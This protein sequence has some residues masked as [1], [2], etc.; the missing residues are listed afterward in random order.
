MARR[1]AKSS[2]PEARPLLL[3]AIER[4]RTEARVLPPVWAE[5]ESELRRFSRDKELYAYQRDAVNN[6][7]WA[8]WM[9]YEKCGDYRPDE[10]AEDAETRKRRFAMETLQGGGSRINYALETW[11]IHA[12]KEEDKDRGAEVF[13]ALSERIRPAGTEIPFDALCNRMGFWMATGSGKTLVMVKLIENLRRL[14]DAGEIPERKVLIL[15]PGSLLLEQIR[16]TVA[17]YNRASRRPMDLVSLREWNTLRGRGR[18]AIFYYDAANISDERKQ[19]RVDWRDFENNGEWYVLLDEAHRGTKGD[20]KRQ[21]YYSLL[22]REG[23]LFNFSATFADFLDVCTTGARFNL[24]DFIQEGYGKH[25]CLCGSDFREFAARDDSR[26]LNAFAKGEY[27]DEEK[28][29]VVLKSALALALVKGEIKRLREAAKTQ[30]FSPPPYHDPLMVTMTHSV[31]TPRSDLAA[32]FNILAG[33]AAPEGIDAEEFALARREFA[34]DLREGSFLFEDLGQRALRDL[35]KRAEKLTEADAR[36]A[37]FLTESPGSL[38]IVKGESGKEIAIQLQTAAEP[39]GLIRIGDTGK[40]IKSAEEAGI[41]TGETVRKESFF[42]GL[43]TSRI[44]ALMGSRAFVESW[45]S[46]RP[47]VLNFVNI[48]TVKE[49]MKF[50]VQSIG[51]GVRVRPLPDQRRRTSAIRSEMSGAKRRVF[52]DTTATAAA[53]SLFVFAARRKAV[54]GALQGLAKEAASDDWVRLE[55]VFKLNPRPKLPDGR[56]M[57]LLVPKY[58]ETK[59]PRKQWREFLITEDSER[60]ILDFVTPMPACVLA[61]AHEKS[62]AEIADFRTMTAEG[63]F[64]R[65]TESGRKFHSPVSAI[66][67]V[68]D[69][70]RIRAEGKKAESVRPLLA[71][72]IVH[73]DRVEIRGGKE[74]KK[75]LDEKLSGVSDDM[76]RRRTEAEDDFLAKRIS[77]EEFRRIQRECSSDPGTRFSEL[78]VRDLAKHYYTPLVAATDKDKANYIRRIV[79]EESEVR[80]LNDLAE[81][82]DSI[83]DG[84]EGWMFSKLDENT[85]KVFI[86]YIDK[87][88]LREFHPDFVFWM[89]RG[90]E[91]RIVFV[92]PKGMAHT[93]YQHKLDGYARL[94]KEKGKLRKF[95]C[96]EWRKVTVALLCYNPDANEA[97]EQYGEYWTDDPSNIFAD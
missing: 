46:A 25:I 80:F 56:E 40:W 3:A 73:F 36:R 94:F 71:S 96:E 2:G 75:L 60:R 22:A 34:E 44:S 6:A 41:V 76:E 74:E 89:C 37:V 38:E 59:L 45:D 85:D 81:K 31:N 13:A 23:F 84:W 77:R 54:A 12:H 30:G 50:I 92:D 67:G 72:D 27:G 32:Y 9:Y 82:A 18:D 91:Y 10:T 86:P 5:S 4:A 47:N 68:F 42:K 21:A 33:L 19:V 95:E 1:R 79:K 14:M 97:P 55:G 51:R 26:A 63:N 53:E 15:A 88:E 35:S 70:L 62:P 20:S 43:E 93:D 48:G 65:V 49:A 61:V 8:L 78:V 24:G 64:W 69:Y 7:L 90:D 29:R 57:P 87:G 66:R 17:E 83:G 52:D 16:S 28:R 11:L 39:F 58:K